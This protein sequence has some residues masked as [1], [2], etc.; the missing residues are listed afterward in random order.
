MDTSIIPPANKLKESSL[1][2]VSWCLKDV[3][4]VASLDCY[5]GALEDILSS[6]ANRKK[7]C[8]ESLLMAAF[9][10]VFE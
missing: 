5:R 1:L 9:R 10:E 3:F 6:L 2:H 7:I 8:G 4:I